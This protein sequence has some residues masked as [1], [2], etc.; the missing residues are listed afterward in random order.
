MKGARA[1]PAKVSEE[2]IQEPS[3]SLTLNWLSILGN[4]GKTTISTYIVKIEMEANTM[5]YLKNSHLIIYRYIFYY[6]RLATKFQLI[7]KCNYMYIIIIKDFNCNF[8]RILVIFNEFNYN[9][10]NFITHFNGT[11]SVKFRV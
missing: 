4:D 3:D 2:R 11:F 6:I 7:D 10:M 8:L 5:R 9:F 1:I